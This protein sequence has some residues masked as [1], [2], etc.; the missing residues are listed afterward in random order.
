[1]EGRRGLEGGRG[2]WKDGRRD[3]GR[4]EWREGG[5]SLDYQRAAMAGTQGAD[6][7]PSAQNTQH[8]V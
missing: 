6:K 4:E 5:R 8:A 3:G 1:M 7:L 2:G